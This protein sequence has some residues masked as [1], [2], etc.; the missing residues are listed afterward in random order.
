MVVFNQDLS[1]WN[2][3]NVTECSEFTTRNLVTITWTKPKPNFTNCDP[4]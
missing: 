1:N 2:V 4:N 3:D